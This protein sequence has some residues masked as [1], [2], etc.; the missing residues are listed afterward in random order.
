MLK[1]QQNTAQSRLLYLL[2]NVRG[3]SHIRRTGVLSGKFEKNTKRVAFDSLHTPLL[4]S[5]LEA[6][7]FQERLIQLLNS[8]FCDR[9]NRIKMGKEVSSYKL[10]NRGCP[11]GSAL[12]PLLWNIFQND[13]HLCPSTELSV[14]TDDHQMYH[15]GHNQE[16]VISK[17]VHVRWCKSNLQVGNL[18][19]YQTLN[20]GYRTATAG[21]ERAS[22]RSRI[23]NQE[24]KPERLSNARV[25]TAFFVLPNFHSCFY[26]SIENTVHV[27]YFLNVHVLIFQFCIVFYINMC[28]PGCMV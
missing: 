14:Y 12:G 17:Q 21:S 11:Q 18:K 13:L 9:Y 28:L 6:N 25:P 20:I 1:L 5:K 2:P 22:R 26:N 4:L 8:Y 3:V 15:S 24:I 10:V 7:S 19:R 27:F 16:E 23:N